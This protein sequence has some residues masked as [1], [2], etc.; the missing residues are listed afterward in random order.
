MNILED[1]ICVAPKLASFMLNFMAEPATT[2]FRIYDRICQRKYRYESIII[3][4]IRGKSVT[5]SI[6]KKGRKTQY[7]LHTIMVNHCIL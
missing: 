2:R 1:V 5:L 6:A 3:I 4:R 7:L